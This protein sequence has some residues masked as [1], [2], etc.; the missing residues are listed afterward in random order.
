M[1]VHSDE[2]RSRVVPASDILSALV[3]VVLLLLPA[4][5]PA[6][7]YTAIAN[8]ESAEGQLIELIGLQTDEA[9]RIALIE[10]FTRSYPKHPACAWAY[11]QLQ[12][13]AVQA[14][15]WDN[16][17]ANGEKLLA[18]NPDDMETAQLN[19]KS[20]EAKGDRVTVKLW[21]DYLS[22]V[23]ERILESPPPKDPEQLEEWK[24]Q[25]AIAAQFAA[26]DEYAIYKKALDAADPRQKIK[27]LDELLK[28]NPDTR[29]LPQALVIYLNSY[30]AMGDRANSLIYSEKILKTDPTNEDALLGAAESYLARGTASD[31]VLSYSSKIIEIMATKRKPAIVR[32]EDWQRKKTHYTGT[33]HWMMGNTFISQNRFALADASLRAALPLLKDNGQSVASILFYLGWANYKLENYAEAARFYKQCLAIH[34]QFQ[35]QATKNLNAIRSEHNLPD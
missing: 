5:A 2:S 30:R 21:S 31:K 23:A 32:D 18:I 11:Q 15:D 12:L 25:T 22:R 27:L 14:H 4:Q 26:Q 33:A 29:Y 20:A 3:A 34:S 6:Q 16:A 9:K 13:S 1:P 19:L 10:R 7:R 28:R 24:K 17:I 8:P 35:E